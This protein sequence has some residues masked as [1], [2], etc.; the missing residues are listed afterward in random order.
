[1]D[2]ARRENASPAAVLGVSIAVKE[3]AQVAA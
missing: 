3:R 2:I 1:M